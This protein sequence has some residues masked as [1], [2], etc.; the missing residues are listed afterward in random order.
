MSRL[1]KV[2]AGAMEAESLKF[3]SKSQ[4]RVAPQDMVPYG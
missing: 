2:V 3:H 4:G 1:P